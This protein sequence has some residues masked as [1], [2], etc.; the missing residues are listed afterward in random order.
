MSKRRLL[1]CALVA[2]G[3]A[4]CSSPGDVTQLDVREISTGYFDE[5]VVDGQN[6]IVPLLRFVLHNKGAEPVSSV[7]LNVQFKRSVDDGPIDEVLARA[8]DAKGV[9]PQQNTGTIT[10][11]AKVGYTGQQTRAQMLQHSGFVDIKAR[12]FA[13]AGSGQWTQIGEFP[14]ERR[15][16][17]Q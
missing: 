7:Q 13:K 11:R 2:A 16:I 14:I 8:V 6:K 17:T 1:L 3:A 4:S 15:V 10:V 12:V 9:Q 5:G